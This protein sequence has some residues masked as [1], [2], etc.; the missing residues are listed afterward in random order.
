[1]SAEPSP[2]QTWAAETEITQS[3][4]TQTETAL[5][6]I[7]QVEAV[8]SDTTQEEEAQA[9]AE[10]AEAQITQADT[11]DVKVRALLKANAEDEEALFEQLAAAL[12]NLTSPATGSRCLATRTSHSPYRAPTGT[13]VW[14][15]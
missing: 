9:D 7:N 1:M 6:E 4:T 10:A 11:N 5:A 3:E 12:T 2:S 14:C 8:Q 13:A 15:C